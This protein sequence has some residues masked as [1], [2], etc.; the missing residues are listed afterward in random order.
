MSLVDFLGVFCTFG[1]EWII[2]RHSVGGFL[3]VFIISISKLAAKLKNK[4]TTIIG[5]DRF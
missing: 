3:C 1:C 5:V 2:Y 4:L